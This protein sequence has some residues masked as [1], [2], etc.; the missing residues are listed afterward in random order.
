MASSI[1]TFFGLSLVPKVSKQDRAILE[2]VACSQLS[3]LELRIN[4]ISIKHSM[5]N[6]RD[7]LKVYQR[8]VGCYG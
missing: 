5:K 6:Q 3:T 7:K 1:A 8:K 4:F 2:S